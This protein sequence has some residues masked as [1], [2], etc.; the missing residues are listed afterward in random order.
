MPPCRRRPRRAPLLLGSRRVARHAAARVA[1]RARPGGARGAGRAPSSP[2]GA[3]LGVVGESGSASPPLAAAGDGAGA[4]H[5]RAASSCSWPRPRLL[6]RRATKPGATSRWCS[7]ILNGSLDPRQTVERIVTEPLV[8]QGARGIRAARREARCCECFAGGLRP[9][10]GQIPARVLRRPAPAHRHRRAPD[11]PAPADRGRRAGERAGRVG[12]GQVLNLMQDLQ[13]KSGVTYLLIS[14]TWPWCTTQRRGRGDIGRAKS[15]SRAKPCCSTTRSP[16]LHPGPGGCA[17]G[18]L[19]RSVLHRRQP[20]YRQPAGFAQGGTL[21]SH[22]SQYNDSCRRAPD[23]L[24]FFRQTLPLQ[25]SPRRQPRHSEVCSLSPESHHDESPIRSATWRWL[26][27]PL[28]ALPEV[29]GA[30]LRIPGAGHGLEPWPGPDR[31]CG[32]LPS[33]ASTT[34]TK[35]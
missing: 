21:K 11:H 14:T 13:Q 8:G 28:A 32:P 7:R 4:A 20:R 10:P 6:G 3:S 27:L 29:R 35:R 25:P 33:H 2:H 22:S 31:R 12:A 5:A 26:P 19:G 16:S 23:G 1:V 17:A 24:S 18:R 34:F 9:R 15:S 30:K